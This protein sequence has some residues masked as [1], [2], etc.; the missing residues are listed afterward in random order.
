MRTMEDQFWEF[1]KDNPSAYPTFERFTLEVIRSGRKRFGAKAIVERVRWFSMFEERG[2]SWKIN[3]NYTSFLARMFEAM[4]PQHKG[5]FSMRASEADIS[6]LFNVM[7]WYR[8]SD[9]G[10]H[11]GDPSKE[12]LI[13]AVNESAECGRE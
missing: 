4:N 5:F 7:D 1:I 2:G 13:D 3:N 12:D 6:D 9:G 10:V 11:K 8:R